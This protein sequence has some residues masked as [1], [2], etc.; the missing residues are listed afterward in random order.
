MQMAGGSRAARPLESQNRGD[1]DPAISQDVALY[2]SGNAKT[3]EREKRRV[4]NARARRKLERLREE[5][6]LKQ[7]LTDVWDEMSN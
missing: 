4:R 7:W 5:K 2:G 6:A 3:S 1:G